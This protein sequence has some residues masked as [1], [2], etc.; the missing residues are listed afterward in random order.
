MTD[1]EGVKPCPFCGGE[2]ERVTIQNRAG[3]RCADAMC[4]GSHRLPNEGEDAVAAWNTRAAQPS[5]G[6]L[7]RD[8]LTEAQSLSWFEKTGMTPREIVAALTTPA[9]PRYDQAA[10]DKFYGAGWAAMCAEAAVWVKPDHL[11][12]LQNPSDPLDSVHAWAKPP[13]TGFVALYATPSQPDTGDV[14]ALREALEEIA[15]IAAEESA[16]DNIS[17]SDFERGV[18]AARLDTGRIALAALSKPNA[19]GREG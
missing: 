5:A 16:M 17:K 7:V 1:T 18:R 2:A 10:M 3:V 19:P 8:D 4:A 6:A 9:Q 15:D 14:A 13:A 12:R 11:R